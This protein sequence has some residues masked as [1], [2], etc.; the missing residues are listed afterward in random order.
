MSE[1]ETG[2]ALGQQQRKKTGKA[3]KVQQLFTTHSFEES[4][5]HLLTTGF[6]LKNKRTL[7]KIATPEHVFFFSP[8]IHK[9]F[10]PKCLEV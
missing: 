4:Q 2:F 1:Q 3:P 5:V 10:T 9:K 8:Q 6:K 7:L